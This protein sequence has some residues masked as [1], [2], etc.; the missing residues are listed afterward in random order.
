V[1]CHRVVRAVDGW[2]GWGGD[3]EVKTRLLAME[4][5]P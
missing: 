2:S 1:P 5:R 3:T 4:R